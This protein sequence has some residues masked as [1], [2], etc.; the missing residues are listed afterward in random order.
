M[1]GPPAL[2]Q[3]VFRLRRHTCVARASSRRNFSPSALKGVRYC[4]CVK[5]ETTGTMLAQPSH[6]RVLPWRRRNLPR[7]LATCVIF[8]AI[9]GVP[10][11]HRRLIA[12]SSATLP[13]R[14]SICDR[15]VL[16][17]LS[18]RAP[19]RSQPCR[20]ARRPRPLAPNRRQFSRTSQCHS[21]RIDVACSVNA[22]DAIENR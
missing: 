6:S 20:D 16:I 7:T 11:S 19:H 1:P 14:A 13:R 5:L 22:A 4:A 8:L 21:M 3:R 15:G 2:E 18:Q 17:Q 10:R 9:G 12:R